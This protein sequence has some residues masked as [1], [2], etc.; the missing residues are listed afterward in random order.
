MLACMGEGGLRFSD[1]LMKRILGSLSD[2]GEAAAAFRFFARV[3]ERG[4]VDWDLQLPPRVRWRLT[5][6]ADGPFAKHAK[7]QQQQQQQPNRVQGVAGASLDATGNG[8][9]VESVGDG[10]ADVAVS[11]PLGP[12]AFAG[13]QAQHS[14]DGGVDLGDAAP[15]LDD[16]DSGAEAI[17]VAERPSKLPLTRSPAE[18]EAES[19]VEEEA[20]AVEAAVAATAVEEAVVVQA[21]GRSASELRSGRAY[22]QKQLLWSWGEPSQTY[23]LMILACQKAGLLEQAWEVYS[24][25]EADGFTL[26]RCVGV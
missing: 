11:A 19:E 16:V 13:Q 22:P 18:S 7:Q 25:M 24:W 4:L 26:P 8:G 17:S 1:T 2:A 10:D 14:V 21:G 12:A 5:R 6:S 15:S 23:V 20:E 3:R 9:E